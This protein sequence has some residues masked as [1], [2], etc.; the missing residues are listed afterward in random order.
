MAAVVCTWAGYWLSVAPLRAAAPETTLRGTFAWANEPAQKHELRANL[1]AT[2]TNEWQ[3]V[4]D[5]NWKQHPLT[6]TGS[7][8]GDLHNGP[9][10]GTGNTVDG[11]RHFSFDGTAKDGAIEVVHYEITHGKT[12]TGTAELHVVN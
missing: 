1:T 9:V 7:L 12:R 10:T 2:G 6:F 4:W 3:A 8:K 11:K 5:F